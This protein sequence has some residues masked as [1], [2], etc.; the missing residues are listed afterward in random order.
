MGAH[1]IGLDA[2]HNHCCVDNSV[3]CLGCN[4]LYLLSA[5]APHAYYG[6]DAAMQHCC[7]VN[8]NFCRGCNQAYRNATGAPH[9]YYGQDAAMQHCCAVN[10]N[11][12]RGCNQA[13][14][15]ATGAPHTYYGQDASEQHCCAVN[16]DVCLGCNEPYRKSA[17]PPHPYYGEDASKQHCCKANSAVCGICH[18]PV[19]NGALH[20]AARDLEDHECCPGTAGECPHCKKIVC[21]AVCKDKH[22]ATKCGHACVFTVCAC[23]GKCR[24]C[25]G[26]FNIDLCRTCMAPKTD[27]VR[28]LTVEHQLVPGQGA[29]VRRQL[30]I[31][32]EIR[33]TAVGSRKTPPPSL[34]SLEVDKDIG[35]MKQ[36]DRGHLFALE[37]NGF[38][39]NCNIVPMNYQ[40]NRGGKWRNMELG[41]GKLITGNELDAAAVN[42]KVSAQPK[43]ASK[44]GLS[45]A[46]KNTLNATWSMEIRLIYDDERGDPRV[47]VWFYVRI[48]KSN[49]LIA[50]F[51]LANQCDKA[52]TMPHKD[53]CAEFAAAQA[54][55]QSLSGE[56]LA[57]IVPD[58]GGYVAG[59]ALPKRPP[60]QLLQFMWEVSFRESEKAPKD[61]VFQTMELG[62]QGPSTAYD[63]FQREYLR[64]FVRW[65][66]RANG[67]KL[68]S[69][70][71]ADSGYPDEPGDTWAELSECGGREAPEVDHIF[72]S[73]AGGAN[74]YLNGRL[75]SFQ[76]NH[77][78]RD[79]PESSSI[80]V[81]AKLYALYLAG[82]LGI[83]C[84]P[85]IKYALR[86]F[87]HVVGSNMSPPLKLTIPASADLN[88]L[89]VRAYLDSR[90]ADDVLFL[91]GQNFN[92]AVSG[93]VDPYKGT[94]WDYVA[95]RQSY[96]QAAEVVKA[97]QKRE[98]DLRPRYEQTARSHKTAVD[99]FT[100]SAKN[101][102]LRKQLDEWIEEGGINL[103]A[104]PS[105][106]L[107]DEGGL[108]N[109]TKADAVPVIPDLL[110][111]PD[112]QNSIKRFELF[113]KTVGL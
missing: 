16:A 22:L 17:G 69:D 55:Y 31:S 18:K 9:T 7:A 50:H 87:E 104:A 82:E 62:V 47:P 101:S 102:G 88:S 39:D 20:P 6:Q 41:A 46:S 60:N 45:L 71:Q 3:R 86:G 80:P 84:K 94:Q 8:G 40:F 49:S 10:G 1:Y 15:N 30:K 48:L 72:P 34:S 19:R 74:S 105:D 68:L 77:T 59:N 73:R 93:A 28:H 92:L 61:R 12:C 51:S 110:A 37:L 107:K 108:A 53:E 38:D 100:N 99:S 90:F 42:G 4:A 106:V 25:V 97:K 24:D 83:I 65:K 66:N 111:D 67:W 27:D 32:G 96:L 21:T 91:K 75:V 56:Q 78:Y 5:G 98:Q 79:K 85:Q 64:A 44:V 2:N 70:A 29:R 76:H 57:K 13:Y 109:P 112:Y 33:S 23:C 63:S 14:R 36:F 58:V 11:F 52:V 89:D 81:S 26:G 103:L 95:P 35:E 113:K 43:T 54:I